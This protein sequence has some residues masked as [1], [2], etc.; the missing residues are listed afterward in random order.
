MLAGSA[1]EAVER[2]AHSAM[3]AMWEPGAGQMNVA[4]I[5]L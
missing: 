5:Y 1:G 3:F 2:G 4:V